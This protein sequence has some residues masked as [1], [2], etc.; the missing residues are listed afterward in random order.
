M[1]E[2]FPSPFPVAL[3]ALALALGCPEDRIDEVWTL[4]GPCEIPRTPSEAVRQVNYA[5]EL[6]GT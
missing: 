2:S 5:L 3:A 1:R 4:L 6:M